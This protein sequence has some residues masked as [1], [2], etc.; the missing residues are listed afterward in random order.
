MSA[1]YE[2]GENNVLYRLSAAEVEI[3]TLKKDM[4]FGNG[5]PGITTRMAMAED[6]V[7]K[8][9]KNLAKIVWLAVATLMT[10]VGFVIEQ[11]I[12]HGPH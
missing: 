3:A 12:L 5:K 9:N 11:N 10:V 8:I 2:H 1:A 6:T 4:Y 7:D